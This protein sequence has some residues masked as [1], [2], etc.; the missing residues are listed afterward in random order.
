VALDGTNSFASHALHGHNGR[1]R[2]LTHGHPLS[3]HAAITPVSVC[4]GHSQG[5]ALPP[6]YLRPQDGQANQD[7]ARAAAKRW[8]TTPAAQVAPPGGTL[9]GD[10]L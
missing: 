5:I 8:L 4:P 9:L 6:E 1:T 2:P 10:D 7:G 3:S